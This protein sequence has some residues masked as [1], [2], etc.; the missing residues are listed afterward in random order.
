MSVARADPAT[1]L[2]RP[3]I[4]ERNSASAHRPADEWLAAVSDT[5]LEQMRGG[6]DTGSGLVV[7]FGVQRAVY[8]NGNM[9][10]TTSFNIPDVGKVSG[11]Q[12]DMLSAAAAVNLVQNGPGNTIQPGALSQAIGATVIQNT[13][14][15][16]SIQ[17]LTVINTATNSLGLLKSINAQSSLRDAL[18]NAVGS[19]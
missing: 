14:N 18:S 6:F 10:T 8:I 5:N 17:N 2:Q 4:K 9:I 7:S 16:Q 11:A 15:N 3:E 1:P 13:L 19:R 12:A